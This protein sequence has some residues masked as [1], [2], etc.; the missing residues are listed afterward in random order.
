MPARSFAAANC[1]EFG[2]FVASISCGEPSSNLSRI[3]KINNSTHAFGWRFLFAGHIGIIPET[4]LA[5]E[6]GLEV[7]NGIVVDE[8]DQ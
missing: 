1:R 2:I 7:D 8:Y 4:G 5:E 3:R 6:A